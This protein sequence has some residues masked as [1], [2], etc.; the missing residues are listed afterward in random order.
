MQATLPEKRTLSL[1][2]A[3]RLYGVRKQTLA[4]LLASGA[5][6][7]RRVGRQWHI[8]VE[9]LDRWARGERAG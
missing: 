9:E 4:D 8:L 5:I 6:P 7:A 3:A 1:S 2:A